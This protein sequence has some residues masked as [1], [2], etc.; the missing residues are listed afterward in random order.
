MGGLDDKEFM[1]AGG[2]VLCATAL[3][4]NIRIAQQ[5]AYK[6]LENIHFKDYHIRLDIGHQAINYIKK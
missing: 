4:E 6:L 2:R 3:G 5:N 1:T